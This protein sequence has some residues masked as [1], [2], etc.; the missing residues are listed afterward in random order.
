MATII[1]R[2]LLNLFCSSPTAILVSSLVRPVLFFM[3]PNILI[4]IPL[5]IFYAI[6][7]KVLFAKF[8]PFLAYKKDE[9]G[10]YKFHLGRYLLT[11]IFITFIVYY[12]LTFLLYY[13]TTK[14]ICYAKDYMP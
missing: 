1:V 5:L 12:V 3:P 13:Y 10:K 14:V 9:S 8:I 7:I 6:S 2:I 11:L 4:F